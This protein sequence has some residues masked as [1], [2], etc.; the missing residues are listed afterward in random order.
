[1]TKEDPDEH[2]ARDRQMENVVAKAKQH[3]D[4]GHMGDCTLDVHFVQQAH[5]SLQA[6]DGAGMRYGDRRTP[7]DQP[8]RGVVDHIGGDNQE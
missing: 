7:S 6:G 4:T 1:M 3:V 5:A 2:T 8:P